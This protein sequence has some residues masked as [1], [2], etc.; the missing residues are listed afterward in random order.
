MS[1]N[2]LVTI[3]EC[4]RNVTRM[5]KSI[6]NVGNKVEDINDNLIRLETRFE[7]LKKDFNQELKSVVK[8]KFQQEGFRLSLRNGLILIGAS[9][10]ISIVV[11]LLVGV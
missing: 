3:R 8:E 11:T 9:S 6:D 2:G 1:K 4:D 10:A 5:E 7:E